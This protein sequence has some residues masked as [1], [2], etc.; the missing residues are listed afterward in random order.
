MLWVPGGGSAPPAPTSWTNITRPARASD[1][2][3]PSLVRKGGTSHCWIVA[4]AS[5]P[6]QVGR[7]SGLCGL[8]RGPSLQCVAGIRP[9]VLQQASVAATS[10]GAAA[11]ILH[12]DCAVQPGPLWSSCPRGGSSRPGMGETSGVGR[13]LGHRLKG[14]TA[15]CQA[16]IST[17]ACQGSD[18]VCIVGGQVHDFSEAA[19]RR[20]RNATCGRERPVVL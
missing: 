20:Q 5:M 17:G 2:H 10:N 6:R 18:K 11:A 7:G 8:R 19:E 13:R 15:E 3:G 1:G 9:R 4:L 16:A 14:R 12:V